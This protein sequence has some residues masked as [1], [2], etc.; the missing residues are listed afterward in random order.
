[1]TGDEQLC[2]Q[3]QARL[4]QIVENERERCARIAEMYAADMQ[5]IDPNFETAGAVIAGLIRAGE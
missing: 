1:M 5:D 4:W 2:P 3:C